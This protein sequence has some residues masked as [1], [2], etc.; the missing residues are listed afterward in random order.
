[1]YNIKIIYVIMHYILFSIQI[2]KIT[3]TVLQ[4]KWY[5]ISD[6]LKCK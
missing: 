6:S 1:M 4:L 5:V 3:H 2:G